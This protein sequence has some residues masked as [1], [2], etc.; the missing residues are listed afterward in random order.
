MNK[1]ILILVALLLLVF[2][3]CGDDTPTPTSCESDCTYE[4]EL[5]FN[6]G[7]EFI[8]LIQNGIKAY[9]S[10]IDQ[11][12]STHNDWDAWT[13]EDLFIIYEEGE[14]SQ[15][16][17]DIVPDPTNPNNN[18][19][20]TQITE[21]HHPNRGRVQMN[22]YD[23][24]CL[25]E[26]YQKIKVYFPTPNMEH[27]KTYENTIDFLSIFEYWNN[28]NWGSNSENPFRI[29]VSLHKDSGVDNDFFFKVKADEKTKFGPDVDPTWQE[30]NF[31]Y[32]I[33]FGEWLEIEVYL[34]EGKGI[35]GSFYMSVTDANNGKTELFNINNHT[36]NPNDNCPD[37]FKHIQPIKLYVGKNIIDHMNEGGYPLEIY[38]DDLEIFKNKVPESIY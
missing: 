29:T 13:D 28:K 31:T 6:G 33:P 32:N 20:L 19:L 34:L 38:W 17:A 16:L 37:G 11:A 36:V 25:R 14:T 27:L 10:G 7:F 1:V 4:E 12:F 2:N 22:F 8:T 23:N 5:L 18:V 3:A 24:E 30:T 9:F 15:R 35:E 21:S 26:Y